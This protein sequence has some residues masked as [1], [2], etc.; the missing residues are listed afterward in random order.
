[1]V[2]SRGSA[3]GRKSRPRA[4]SSALRTA[5]GPEPLVRKAGDG[6]AGSRCY[7]GKSADAT[8]GRP[9]GPHQSPRARETAGFASR[10]TPRGLRDSLPLSRPGYTS[11]SESL[12][13]AL[14]RHLYHCPPVIMPAGLVFGLWHPV[15]LQVRSRLSLPTGKSG[16]DPLPAPVPSCK[17]IYS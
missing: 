3:R 15:S 16:Q 7:C 2:P 12:D 11:F 6:C 1:M 9:C 5:P 13:G 14:S 17:P 8:L 4:T 10:P